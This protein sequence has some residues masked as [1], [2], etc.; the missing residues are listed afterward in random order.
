VQSSHSG[1][2]HTGCA[3]VVSRADPNNQVFTD[4]Q[5]VR[6]LMYAL[7][8]LQGQLKIDF[9][10]ESAGIKLLSGER[11]MEVFMLHLIRPW[12]AII[13]RRNM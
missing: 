2:V 11:S 3:P 8:Y 5:C 7:T 1:G 9:E 10:N 6:F 12:L 4:F 13:A